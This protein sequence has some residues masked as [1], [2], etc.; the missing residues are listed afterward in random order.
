M[1]I[2]KVRFVITL[3]VAFVVGAAVMFGV[4]HFGHDSA[5][6]DENKLGA[7]Q[8]QIDKYYLNDCDQEELIE[9]VYKGYVAGLGDPYS[10]YMSKTEYESWLA[11]ATGDY[12]GIG[13]TFTEDKNGNFVVLEVTKDSP[14]EKADVKSGDY[15]LT[16]DGE[17]FE[18]SDVMAAAIRGQAGTNVTIEFMQDEKKVSKTITRDHIIQQSVEYKMLDGDIGYIQ[19]S[20][21][22]NSTSE[23]FDAA[24]KNLTAKGAKSLILD[25][26]DNC[27]G[28]VNECVEVADEFLDEGPVCYVEDKNGNTESYDAEDGKTKL[29]T[30]VLV[31]ENSASAS[32]ILAG[33]MHDNDYT[34]IG[35]K[36]FGKGVIQ[37]TEQLSDGSALKL[38]IMQYLSPDKHVIHKKGIKPDIVVEDKEKTEADEQLDKA[39]EELKK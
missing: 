23:D 30:V 6:I 5:K 2:S 8:E 9:Y 16:V 31:N 37:T 21:F 35:E 24:L 32:E 10:L 34:L 11:S 28:L 38:T 19:I 1:Q 12:D 20:K 39:I 4:T 27:G 15:I 26:R 18:S 33:A 25:L 17:T 14:A 13:M 3:A 36:T 7:I 22:I 29:P